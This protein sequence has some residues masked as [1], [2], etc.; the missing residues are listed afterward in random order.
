MTTM[1]HRSC[2]LTTSL[3]LFL[4]ARIPV[5]TEEVTTEIVTTQANCP[6]PFALKTTGCYYVGASS[7]TWDSARSAC[8][9][10]NS[11]VAI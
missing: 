11:V 10:S 2:L 3:I 4:S 8:Q 9:S 6:S 5:T 7:A 1:Q